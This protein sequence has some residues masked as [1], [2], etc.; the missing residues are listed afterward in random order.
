VTNTTF[1]IARNPDADSTLPHLFDEEATD[2]DLG[3]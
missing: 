2:L 3:F 1:L